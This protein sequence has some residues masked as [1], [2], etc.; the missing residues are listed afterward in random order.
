MGCWCC[1][2]G[3]R[4]RQQAAAGSRVGCIALWST[5]L[6]IVGFF[7]AMQRLGAADAATISTLEPIVTV[8]LAALFLSEGMGAWQAMGGALILCAVI[9]M[10]RSGET[11][12][13]TI[14][15]PG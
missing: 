9:V 8:V 4:G 5:V 1:G 7:A 15:P 6:A 13:S 10:A 2:A 14:A 12:E 11:E 3:H